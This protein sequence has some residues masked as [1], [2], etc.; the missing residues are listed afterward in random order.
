MTTHNDDAHA[1][2]TAHAAQTTHN[3][4]QPMRFRRS[5]DAQHEA[6]ARNTPTRH[7]G[8]TPLGVRRVTCR[9]VGGT[10]PSRSRTPP[11]WTHQSANLSPG[12]PQTVKREASDL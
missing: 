5:D 9:G 2:S 6:H 3:D 12:W 10:M 1:L 8:C 4:A 11:A 7:N